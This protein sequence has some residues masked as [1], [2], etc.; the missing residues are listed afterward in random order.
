MVRLSNNV[1]KGVYF[2]NSHIL[3]P[4]EVFK[5]FLDGCDFYFKYN[6]KKDSVSKGVPRKTF[7]EKDYY[8]ISMEKSSIDI[9]RQH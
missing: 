2:L 5:E 6:V 7:T 4:K 1:E 8:S 3:V 9:L